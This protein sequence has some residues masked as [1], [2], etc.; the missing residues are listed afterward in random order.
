MPL[1]RRSPPPL[2]REGVTAFNDMKHAT[3]TIRLFSHICAM[4]SV[5]KALANPQGARRSCA[6]R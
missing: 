2:S 3:I 1:P 4:S 6:T 5:P